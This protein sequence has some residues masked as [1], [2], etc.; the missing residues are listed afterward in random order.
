MWIPTQ[1]EAVHMYARF[2]TARHGNA[3][4]RY[5]RKMADKLRTQGDDVG[6]TI[7]DRVAESVE[8]RGKQNTKPLP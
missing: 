7:W 4:G 6:S 2:L 1:D 5:A 3:A 8:D